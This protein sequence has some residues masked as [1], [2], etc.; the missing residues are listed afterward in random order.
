MR[1]RSSSS[2]SARTSARSWCGKAVTIDADGLASLVLADD[3][4]EDAALVLVITDA[5]GRILAQQPT[6]KGENT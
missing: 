2:T 4:Y 3:R 1:S 5:D 6:R